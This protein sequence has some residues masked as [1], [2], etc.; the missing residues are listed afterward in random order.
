MIFTLCDPHVRVSV[1]FLSLASV[2]WGLSSP[3]ACSACRHQAPV[4][5]PGIFN[6]WC[7]RASLIPLSKSGPRQAWDGQRRRKPGNSLLLLCRRLCLQGPNPVTGVPHLDSRGGRGWGSWLGRLPHCWQVLPLSQRF[8]KQLPIF[9]SPLQLAGVQPIFL[10]ESRM[11]Y[12][13]NQ[14]WKRRKYPN[15]R[16]STVYN[17]QD[18]EA[19]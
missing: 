13:R 4:P 14:N 1:R 15:A 18:M 19:T 6:W 12:S 9:N 5:L 3:S 16:R 17:R 10:S 8:G 2:L 11:T 7:Q